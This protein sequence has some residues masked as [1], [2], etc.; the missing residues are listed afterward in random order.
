[1]PTTPRARK[2]I[3]YAMDELRGLEP[4]SKSVGTEYLLLGLLREKKE[5]LPRC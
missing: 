4:D 5:L 3:E 1:M 2:V